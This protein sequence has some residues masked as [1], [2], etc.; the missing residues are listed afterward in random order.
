MN[1]TQTRAKPPSGPSAM[2]AQIPPSTATLTDN[3]SNSVMAFPIDLMSWGTAHSPE[4]FCCC[5]FAS[6]PQAR[7]DRLERRDGLLLIAFLQIKHELEAFLLLA[8]NLAFP[9]EVIIQ[10]NDLV[11]ANGLVESLTLAKSLLANGSHNASSPI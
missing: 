8:D 6:A 2:K 4:K 11:A 3:A 5:V 1:P 10:T 7:E 9:H